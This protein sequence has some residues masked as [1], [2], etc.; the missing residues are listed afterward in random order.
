MSDEDTGLARSRIEE[1]VSKDGFPN[2]GIQSGERIIKDLDVRVYIYG[3]T[4]VDTLLLS[5]G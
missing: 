2:V 5:T 3:T 4:D 1:D